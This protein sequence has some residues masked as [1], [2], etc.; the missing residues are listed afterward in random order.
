MWLAARCKWEFYPL[1]EGGQ[2][3]YSTQTGGLS[4]PEVTGEIWQD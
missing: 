2:Y 4:T 3:H 1:L